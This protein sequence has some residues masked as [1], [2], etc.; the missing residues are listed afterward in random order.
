[1][2]FPYHVSQVDYPLSSNEKTTTENPRKKNSKK[3]NKNVGIQSSKLIEQLNN[4]V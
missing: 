4:T 1:M 2:I 3:Q